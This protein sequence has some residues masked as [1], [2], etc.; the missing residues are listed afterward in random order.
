VQTA[1]QFQTLAVVEREYR[2]GWGILQRY[3]V[4]RQHLLALVGAR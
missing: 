2:W 4:E 1:L 3:G